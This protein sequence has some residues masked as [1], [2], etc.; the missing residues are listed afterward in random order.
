MPQIIDVPGMGQVEFPDGMAD[1]QIAAAIK[2]S[3]QPQ[4]A[5]PSNVM[6]GVNAANKGIAAIPDQLLNTPNRLMN[7]GRAAYGTAATAL[8]RPDLAPVLTEDPNLASRAFEK[9]G[10]IRNELNPVTPG[11]RIADTAIQ[12]GVAGLVS[13]ASGIRQALTNTAIGATSGGA[14]GATKEATGSDTAALMA[15]MIVPAAAS[16]AITSSR[17]KM[18]A[19]QLRK[20][21]NAVRDQTL[22][23][24]REAGY[25]FSP[26]ETNPGALN[27]ALEGYAGKLS[28]RQ[29]ASQKNQEVTNALAKQAVGVPENV[30]LTPELM[31]QVRRSAY[32]QGYRPV[33]AAGEIRPGKL[34]KQ[35][36]DDIEQ[37]YTGAAKSFPEAVSNEV[38]QMVEGLRVTKFDSGDAV[39]MAQIL[40]D[41]AGKS[42]ASGNSAL[43][44]AQRA[45]ATVI[46]DQIE[47]GLAGQGQNGQQL[48]NDFREARKTMAKTHTIESAIRPGTGNVD[49]QKFAAA[50]RKGKP[51]SGELEK[52]GMTADAFPTSMKM[53]EAA[54]AIPGISPLDVFS[55]AGMGIAGAG[56][57]GSPLGA[58]AALIPAGRPLARAALLSEPYQRAKVMPKYKN[59]LLT[60]ALAQGDVTNARAN[61]ALIAQ[62]LAAQQGE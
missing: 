9:M 36:L 15:G 27:Q 33:E 30:P 20:E 39:K 40:R 4:R 24:A 3:M 52:I 49:A 21:Q 7:L 57:T 22:A 50:L 25:V 61:Q 62:V 41:D 54:G 16:K 10:L 43:G 6:M 28:T 23:Q 34:Y 51:L 12:G 45:G 29:L 58:A 46:E 26:T 2:A 35:A 8:G 32:D 37:K 18:A 1:D 11:Q 13:P 44:K 5:A 19:T 48:L 55:G 47:R 56:L 17:A 31:Q 42:F 38:K 14:A 53:P 60:R 59:S